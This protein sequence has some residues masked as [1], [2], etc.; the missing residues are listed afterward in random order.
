MYWNLQNAASPVPP[1]RLAVDIKSKQGKLVRNDGVFMP[2]SE[3]AKTKM[4]M[5]RCQGSCRKIDMARSHE[6]GGCCRL[7]S[8]Q[9]G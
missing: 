3:G 5:E 8:C 1:S 9:E 2:V 4:L 7:E 6:K